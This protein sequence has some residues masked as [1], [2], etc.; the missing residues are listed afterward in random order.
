MKGS[1]AHH[2]RSFSPASTLCRRSNMACGL[3]LD[4]CSTLCLVLSPRTKVSCASLT[5]STCKFEHSPSHGMKHP[6][7][8]TLPSLCAPFLRC[9]IC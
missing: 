6:G 5:P 8:V 9:A 1:E 3:V 4:T 7:T 2:D